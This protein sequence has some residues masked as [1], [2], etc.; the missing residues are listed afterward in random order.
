MS[1]R[2][3]VWLTRTVLGALLA[4]VVGKIANGTTNY[5]GAKIEPVV[6]AISPSADIYIYGPPLPPPDIAPSRPAILQDQ[7]ETGSLQAPVGPPAAKHA[8]RKPHGFF[9]RLGLAFDTLLGTEDYRD[10][11]R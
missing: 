8:K 11:A 6:A 3:K 2:T 10:D 1:P 7:L 9:M 4:L 5:I